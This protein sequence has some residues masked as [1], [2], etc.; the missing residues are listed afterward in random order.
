MVSVSCIPLL[1]SRLRVT[2]SIAQCQTVGVGAQSGDWHRARRQSFQEQVPLETR[3]SVTVHGS[4][5]PASYLDDG[6]G[7][8]IG[9][10]RRYRWSTQSPGNGQ[11][12]VRLA[13]QSTV[14]SLVRLE[15]G[16]GAQLDILVRSH[17]TGNGGAPVD[18]AG[19]SHPELW[20]APPVVSITDMLALDSRSHTGYPRSFATIWPLVTSLAVDGG[21]HTVQSNL[22]RPPFRVTSALPTV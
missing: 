19:G 6:A 10:R 21:G 5:G 11:S 2:V 3:I 15:L 14:L 18:N 8:H 4:G 7:H 12:P 1:C 13:Q 22:P 17:I 9:G 16:S 20:F